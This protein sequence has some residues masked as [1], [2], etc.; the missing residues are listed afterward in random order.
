MFIFCDDD[1][2][3]IDTGDIH[4]IIFLQGYL[5][6]TD[7]HVQTFSIWFSL[8]ICWLV[9]ILIF[10][11]VSHLIFVEGKIC[12]VTHVRVSSEKYQFYPHDSGLES[13]FHSHSIKSILFLD[14]IYVT[15]FLGKNFLFFSIFAINFEKH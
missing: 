10:Y 14:Y 6:V 2:I 11:I 5:L 15:L 8:Y 12:L 13:T 9:M 1:D 4:L 7:V 3:R